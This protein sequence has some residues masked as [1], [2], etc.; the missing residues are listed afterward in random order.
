MFIP[1]PSSFMVFSSFF[2]KPARL[3]EIDFILYF[4]SQ[5]ERLMFDSFQNIIKIKNEL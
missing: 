4:L 3:S 2:L 5:S 1:S